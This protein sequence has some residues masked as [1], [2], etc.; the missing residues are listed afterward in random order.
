MAR[1]LVDIWAIMIKKSMRNILILFLCIIPIGAFANYTTV[2]TDSITKQFTDSLPKQLIDIDAALEGL[3]SKPASVQSVVASLQ[4]STLAPIQD[5]I[6][7][8]E[9]PLRI[10]DAKTLREEIDMIIRNVPLVKID[11]LLSENNFLFLPLVLRKH[12]FPFDFRKNLLSYSLYIGKNPTTLYQYKMH[13]PEIEKDMDYIQNMR[14]RALQHIVVTQPELILY[15]EDELPNTADVRNH[16]IDVD[17]T[18]KVKF[19]DDANMV[20]RTRRNLVVQ[21]AKLGPWTRKANA[22]LQFSQNYVSKNWH[23]GGSDNIA[24]LGTLNGKLNYDDKKNIQWENSA[25]WRAGFNSTEGNNIRPLNTNDDIFRV[26]SK[27]G[28]KAK[29]AFFYSGLFDFSTPIFLTYKSVN[30]TDLKAAFMTP[31]R[32]NISAGL[33]YKYKKLISVMVSPLTYKYIYLNNTKV[34]SKLFGIKAGENT[35]SEVGSSFRIQGNYAPT[36]EITFDTKFSFY[37]NYTKVE[38]DWEIIGNFQV[39]RF[40]S[41]RIILNPRYDNTVIMTG[42]DKAKLQF[43]ELLTFGLSYRLLN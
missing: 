38:I 25:E 35:L 22:Y 10:V 42:G 6:I 40:L 21:K 29:G 9:P 37:T 32:L 34:D 33:D 30:S 28:I 8:I 19:I 27:L 17:Y 41:T 39:N 1:N 5:T 24:I 43:K 16:F 31:V 15:S 26:N 3:I 4:D 23:Q 13:V 14:Q 36:K 2:K 12:P 7:N 11:T 18:Q 20:T